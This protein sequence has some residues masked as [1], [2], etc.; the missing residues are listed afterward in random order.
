ME[1]HTHFMPDMQ[2][3][4]AQIAGSILEKIASGYKRGTWGARTPGPAS[5]ILAASSC[6]DSEIE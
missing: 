6:R 4:A 3:E 5:V 2:A 1:I